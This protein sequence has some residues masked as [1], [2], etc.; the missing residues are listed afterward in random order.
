MAHIR[1]QCTV[2]GTHKDTMSELRMTYTYGSQELGSGSATCWL[3][4]H[5]PALLQVL[6]NLYILFCSP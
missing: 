3:S 4:T 2:I 1:W 5:I 6:C